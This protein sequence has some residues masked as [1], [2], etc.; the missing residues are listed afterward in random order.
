MYKSK[1]SKHSEWMSIGPERLEFVKTKVQ[2]RKKDALAAGA[3]SDQEDWVE[4]AYGNDPNLQNLQQVNGGNE[5]NY[6]FQR[7]TSNIGMPINP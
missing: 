5:D 4:E 6:D 1:V 7:T 2:R 3:D